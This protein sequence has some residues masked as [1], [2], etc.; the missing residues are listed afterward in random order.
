MW[1]SLDYCEP[2]ILGSQW[3]NSSSEI[4]IAAMAGPDSGC[5]YMGDF[6]VYRIEVPRGKILQTYTA[7]EAHRVFGEENLPKI[8]DE[9]EDL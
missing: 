1:K 4:L 7:T 3:L 8:I 2:N 5:K 6:V 9:N